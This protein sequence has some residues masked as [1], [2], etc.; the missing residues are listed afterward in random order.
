MKVKLTLVRS[1]GKVDVLVAADGSA[2]V[3]DVAR[4]LAGGA[5][6]VEGMMTLRIHDHAQGRVLDPS[7]PLA[8]A[9]V[10]SGAVVSV[11]PT[12]AAFVVGSSRPAAAL[13]RVLAGP[14]A[15]KE[16]PLAVGTTVVGRGR[17]VEVRLSDALVSKRH[18]RITVGAT[19]EIADLGSANGLIVDGVAMS[20]VPL[21]T[22]TRVVMGDTV[23]AV[24]PLRRPTDTVPPGPT[25]S[26]VRS[27]RVLPPVT[28]RELPA[29]EVPSGAVAR[30]FPLVA[31]AAP[32]LMGAVMF[33]VTRNT[34]SLM[35]VALSPFIMAG[36]WLDSRLTLRRERT[37]AELRFETALDATRE[38]IHQAHRL[39]RVLRLAA[40]PST[41]EVAEA[42]RSYGP[43]LWSRRVEHDEYLAVRLGTGVQPSCTTV[44]GAENGNATAEQRAALRELAAAAA[45][46]S[47]VPVV[48]A[49]RRA[50]AIGLAGPS[51]QIEG[52][53]RGLLL[54]IAGLH[55]PADVSIAAFVAPRT[56]EGWRW[57]T[58]LPHVG[59]PHAPVGGH[60]LADD[61]GVGH[62]VLLGLEEL[63]AR[64]SHRAGEASK[65]E[66]DRRGRLADGGPDGQQVAR[67]SVVLVLVDDATPVD[68][69]RLTALAEDGPA[70][71]VHVL[72]MANAVQ[73]LPA[74][75][76]EF[77]L[78]GQD[79]TATVGNVRTGR[80][81]HPVSVEHL[82]AE[83]A[84]ILARLLAP[85]EDAG[86]AVEDASGLPG[87]V[88]FLT[89][90][91]HELGSS[92]ELQVERW[93]ESGSLIARPGAPASPPRA[94]SLRA[95]VGQAAAEPMMLDLREQ[96]PH[97]LVG[98]TTGAGK[99]EFLQSW[100]LGMATAHSP[101]RVTFL[102]VDYK[103]G[104]AFADCVHL[105]HTVGLVTDLSPHLVRRALTSLRAELRYRE[106]LL[107]AAKAKDLIALEKRGDP[108]AP[109]S[110]II[111]VDEFA[112]LATEVPE[113]VD[114]VVDVAQ[115]G[116]SLGLH[117]IL[118]T[119][120]PAGVIKDNLRANTN[121]RVALRMADE[122]DSN[123]VLGS[124]IAAHVDPALPGRAAVRTGPGRISAFQSAYAGGRTAAQAPPPR[125]EIA[126]LGFG[127]AR[128]WE[129]P[130]AP[131]VGQAE[132]QPTDIARVV[133]VTRE[134][135]RLAGVVEPRKPWLPVLAGAYDLAL[136]H[137]RSDLRLALGVLDDAKRQ[138]QRASYFE[139]DSEG[140]L[141]VYGASGS[142]KSVV[143]RTLAAS[144]AITP[145]GGPV[146]VYGIDAAGGALSPLE[147]LPH[148]GAIIAGD[149]AERVNRL[150]TWLRSIVDERSGRYAACRAA[151][152]DEY[153]RLAG[154]PDEP[155]FL[156]L[157]D[158]FGAFRQEYEGVAS[159]SSAYGVLHQ[160]LADG[161]SVGVHVALT[162]D[163]PGAVPTSVSSTTQRVLVLRQTDENAYLMLD[164]PR[165][166]L[167][168]VS[169]P[170]R[171]VDL[172]DRL[173][174]QVAVLGGSANLAEQARALE[175]LAAAA[176]RD[177]AHTAAPVRRLPDLVP[178]VE[179]PSSVDGLPVLG[180]ADDTL[181]AVG[182]QPSGTFLVSGPSGSGRSTTLL[183]L[184]TALR[185]WRPDVRMYHLTARPSALAGAPL[186]ARTERTMDG[187]L[188]LVQE[189]L[190][191]VKEEPV[192]GPTG[193]VLVV[194][195]LP[196]FLGGPAESPLTEVIKHAKRNGHLVIAEAES[197]S[198]GSTW[199]LVTEVRSGRT[200]IAL[201]PDQME[202][203]LLF[204]TT[205][206]RVSRGDFPAGRGLAVR[207]GKVRRVQ[208][209]H[210]ATDARGGV[211]I[212]VR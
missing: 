54:Q 137:Q 123:D 121:L 154:A 67:G 212:D 6:G 99:S 102:L 15:G 171:A 76:R 3:G 116:R 51:G 159:R 109:P 64:R 180:L 44:T 61:V 153:R 160:L 130:E 187:V 209:G 139:P 34:L 43:L 12:G 50:G 20:R 16:F 115:R 183:H 24:V 75:C 86:A 77:L 36:T 46:I 45:E 105:P 80:Y 112:A 197:S 202:G 173:E 62:R 118:A 107:N 4:A 149:D 71:G 37:A 5:P 92:P 40:H 94:G 70:V 210:P 188:S 14:D 190:P 120:R 27:P 150:L 65:D 113:F 33:S 1:D 177:A 156:L 110:L 7:T 165:D 73:A 211:P 93:R 148:V 103:G 88:S 164:A 108:H 140:N 204:R 9:G 189:L 8:S 21:E 152:I 82:G 114:G 167:S 146:H 162:A 129:S 49:L 23:V 126:D 158:G 25:I 157:V 172:P 100:V 31:M 185:R 184:A 196:D 125:I 85:V 69:A 57:L 38:D 106:H 29:P 63:V 163:R 201:Q 42:V 39:E 182:F 35:F 91:G 181:A 98:G 179:L 186:W 122:D 48:G 97:A 22:S 41:A 11:E 175:K 135:A 10:R 142:G 200:G 47:D 83:D 206:P 168:P 174:L 133:A 192:G 127:G 198:W 19:I 78:L 101:E 155:R 176:P 68:R 138:E 194:E 81:V 104:A 56:V 199:P 72:W 145:R 195:G 2:P 161:R 134:A 17:D 132:N 60:L 66:G 166:V 136:L 28:N 84:M 205:F 141:A 30:K 147:V 79:G 207:G 143:L 74:A 124:P 208:V 52:V 170:G 89:L 203:D 119:Q 193:L 58:W 13:L 117:L 95:L 32:L 53:A 191:L 59:S 169:P 151:T 87:S 111:V 131:A 18:A 144:A 96:G 128:V 26:F 55:S 178:S 90:A